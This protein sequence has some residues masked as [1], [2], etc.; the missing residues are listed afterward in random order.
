MEVYDPAM[1]KIAAAAAVAA[2]IVFA[3][4]AYADDDAY[5]DELSGQGF[6]V[7][8][9]SRP[10]LL[11]AGNG[12]CNDLRNGETPEQVASHSNYPNATPANLLAMARSAKRNL[13]P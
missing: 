2:S 8:W 7:M 13:C 10:F 1:I 12:M 5:L 11:A 6:Q 3:P 4:A 9:Q